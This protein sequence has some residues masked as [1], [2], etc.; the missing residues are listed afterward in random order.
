M[1]FPK[2]QLETEVVVVGYGD[3]GGA[4]AISAHDAGAKVLIVEK[5]G[6]PGGI[7]ITPPTAGM[8]YVSDDIEGAVK[9]FTAIAGDRPGPELVRAFVQG[10]ADGYDLLKKLAEINGA[11]IE[12]GPF[13]GG[14]YPFEG[15]E[16]LRTY[17]VTG[18]PGFTR[19]P[20][21]DKPRGGQ[22]LFKIFY[23][24]VEARKIPIML[25]TPAKRLV[26]DG[27]GTVLGIVV[28]KDGKETAIK[29]SK[30]VIL[31]TGGYEQNQWLRTHCFEGQPIYS[32]APLTNTGDG[33]IMAQK[34]GAAL[35]H[36]WHV[37]GTY[38]FKFPEIPVAM[39]HTFRGPRQDP[40]KLMPW[41]VIDK[42]GKRY[43]DEGP[44]IAF[45][46][47][48]RNMQTYNPDIPGYP[49]IPSYM[50]FDEEGRKLGPIGVCDTYGYYNWSQDNKPEI[51]RGWIL[52]APTIAE[53]AAKINAV[54]ENEKNMKSGVLERTV[55]DW[56]QHVKDR[57]D[58]LGRLPTS[59]MPLVNPPFY[60]IQ[61]W[62]VIHYTQGG[63][64]H[65][66]G[67]RIMDSF[68]QPIPRLYSA[69]QLGSFH[70]HIYQPGGNVGECIASG[71]VSG[72][73]A[74]AER[75]WA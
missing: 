19:F 73:N 32:S 28:E 58:P 61:L 4:A 64:V 60:A 3:A 42:F 72:R 31:A 39:L 56:N 14:T 16:N 65:D 17:F 5:A 12:F 33:V 52:S 41:I 10:L 8:K 27:D 2:W 25:S 70:G 74:A 18:V 29:A 15:G 51:A 57:E 34:V 7:S 55:K 37:H 26:T 22:Y 67:R 66:P 49:Y 44:P 47:P 24:N 75:P 53:L 38:G 62:P 36:M 21:T 6:H 50:V 30:A 48:F 71:M 23:D 11:K 68:G 43:M 54:P 63:P 46:T 13:K 1:K 40:N 9:Y 35:W 59:M 69:G 20:W 45:D